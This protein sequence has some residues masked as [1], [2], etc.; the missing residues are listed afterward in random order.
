MDGAID[1]YRAQAKL[2]LQQEKRN[3]ERNTKLST[4]TPKQHLWAEFEE[5]ASSKRDRNSGRDHKAPAVD[6]FGLMH[7]KSAHP[8]YGERELNALI[9]KYTSYVENPVFIADGKAAH[10]GSSGGKGKGKGKGSGKGKDGPK[11]KGKSKDKGKDKGKGKGSSK[12]KGGKDKGKGKGKGKDKGSS[13]GKGGKGKD[14]GK[15]KGKGK[16][17]GGKHSGGKGQNPK[18]WNTS[19]RKRGK[20]NEWW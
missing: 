12:G 3:E 11:G 2:K 18:N 7:E 19:Y 13:K 16:D 20:G 9:P 14:K 4:M 8:E 1:A 6:H 10:G 17:T 5:F 15:G